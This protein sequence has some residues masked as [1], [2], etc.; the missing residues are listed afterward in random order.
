MLNVSGKLSTYL[1]PNPTLIL[2][3]HFGQKVAS[4]RGRW[5]VTQKRIM[6]HI[7]QVL[8]SGFHAVDSGMQV[9][10]SRFHVSGPRNPTA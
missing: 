5:A 2:S 7:I 3:F 8:A 6:I 4:G 9:V 10:D 1:S